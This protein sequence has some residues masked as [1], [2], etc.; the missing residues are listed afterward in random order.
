MVAVVGKRRGVGVTGKIGGVSFFAFANKEL[1]IWAASV[2]F[3]PM[4]A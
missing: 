4:N 2:E 1:S 3:M